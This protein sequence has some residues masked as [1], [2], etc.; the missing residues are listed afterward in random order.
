MGCIECG[1][2]RGHAP[3]CGQQTREELA[4]QFKVY[5]A[6]WRSMSFQHANRQKE[7]QDLVT[8]WQGKFRIVAAENNALRRKLKGTEAK[9]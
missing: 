1:A 9:A 3:G 5:L 7:L 6:N 8:F 2:V 4:A